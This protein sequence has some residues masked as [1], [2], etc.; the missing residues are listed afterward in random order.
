MKFR[1]RAFATLTAVSLLVLTAALLAGAVLISQ[2][3]LVVQSKTASFASDRSSTL[4]KVDAVLQAV[5]KS[6]NPDEQTFDLWWAGHSGSFGAGTVLVSLSGR[7]NLNSVTPFVLQNSDLKT[8]L[9]GKSVEDFTNYRTN[10]GP[11]SQ[12]SDYKDYFQPPALNQLYAVYS[13]FSVNTAD[14]IVL[15]NVLAARTGSPALASTIRAALRQYRTNRQALTPAD[16]ET[17]IGA[18]KAAVGELMS[19]D[20]ELDVNA[21][22]PTV[23]QAILRDPDFKLDQPD[24][25]V[26]TLLSGRSSKPWNS[27]TLRQALGVEKNSPLL[28]YLGTRSRFFQ[29]EIPEGSRLLTFVF[30]ADYGTE[31]PPKITFRILDMRWTTT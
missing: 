6:W 23:L 10:K 28:P 26:Q 22:S 12:I 15:E 8:T 29:G 17:L 4:T 7:V 9:L 2:Q 20:A 21:A 18:N 27:D 13:M 19:T 5:Q 25:K 30:F 3:V 24:A 14:E 11:F 1:P 16:W 31:S